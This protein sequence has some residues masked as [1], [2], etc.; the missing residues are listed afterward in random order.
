MTNME[1]YPRTEDALHAWENSNSRLVF[2][3]WLDAPYGKIAPWNP[4]KEPAYDMDGWET[5][6]WPEPEVN[7]EEMEDEQ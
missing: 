7:E 4:E 2:S 1:K 5:G 3:Y 6:E